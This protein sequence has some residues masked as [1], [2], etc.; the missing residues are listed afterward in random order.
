[1]HPNH[2]NQWRNSSAMLKAHGEK[3]KCDGKHDMSNIDRNTWNTKT[4]F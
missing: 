2:V 4:R 3:L 1:M